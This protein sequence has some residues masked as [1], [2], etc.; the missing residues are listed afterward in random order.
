MTLIKNLTTS[1]KFKTSMVQMPC[2]KLFIYLAI[3]GNIGSRVK[4]SPILPDLAQSISISSY[5]HFCS[6]FR[7]SK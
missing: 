1:K 5:D 7:R 2:H 4:S 6:S 3:L